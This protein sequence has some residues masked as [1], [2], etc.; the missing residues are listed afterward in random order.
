M[1]AEIVAFVDTEGQSVSINTPGL[2]QLYRKKSGL[3]QVEREALFTLPANRSVSEIR[4]S[5]ANILAF[6]GNCK[7]FVAGA[8]SGLPY[9]ELEKA[10]CSVWEYEGKPREFL[11]E[12]LE[13][14]EEAAARLT[15]DSTQLAMPVPEDL[16]EGCYR[17]SIKAIQ[18]QEAGLTSKQVLLPVI[19]RGEY[20]QLEVLCNHI[21]PWLEGEALAGTVA[22]RKEIL[23]PGEI[24]LVIAKEVCTQ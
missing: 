23:G 21:P 12:L 6:M 4:K 19:R 17:I 9:Y 1:G 16:G 2:L 13:R 3:W 8:I 5:M 20:Y 14:E 7:I 11:D 18:E 15:G 22:Y 10:G 24:R